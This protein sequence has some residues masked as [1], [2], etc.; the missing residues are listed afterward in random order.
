MAKKIRD[1]AY[2]LERLEGEYPTVYADWKAGKYRSMRQA[3]IAAGLKKD[4][5]Q[6]NTLKNAWRKS[7]PSQQADFL[8]WI[9][10][11]SSAGTA[12]TKNSKA[13]LTTTSKPIQTIAIADAQRQLLPATIARIQTIK[14]RRGLKMGDVMREMSYKPLNASLGRALHRPTRLK[15][16]LISALEKWLL[17]N[18]S[19]R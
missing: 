18:Q 3:F 10:A 17:N 13:T 4:T 11:A 14:V 16:D 15:P 12:P 5:S 6:L 1:N 19:I 7:S 8:R 2:Y 9:Q